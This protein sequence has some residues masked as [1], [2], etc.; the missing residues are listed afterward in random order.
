MGSAGLA[1]AIGS[2]AQ[3]AAGKSFTGY[4]DSLGV[5][6]DTVLCVGCRSCEAACNKVND[7]PPP[8]SPFNDLTLLD[9]KRRTTATSYT[10]VNRYMAEGD[11]QRPMFRKNQCNHCLEP[12]CAS[13]CFVKAFSKT[14]SGAVTYDPSVCVGCRYC[15]IACPFEIPS[16]EYDSALSPRVTKCTLC[17]PRIVK[18]QLPGCVESCP[19]EA[20]V[21][22]KR[23]DLIRIARQRIQK[24]PDRY[25]D[26][27]YGEY[28]M[29]GT[30]WL[31]LSGVPFSRLGLREDLGTL[32]AAEYTAG[33]LGAVPMVVGLWPVLLTGVYAIAKRRDKIA[34]EE[35]AQA[36]TQALTQ[37][38]HQAQS[39][40]KAALDKAAKEKEAAVAKAVKEALDAAAKERAQKE[41]AKAA[42]VADQSPASPASTKEDA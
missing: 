31:Y 6:H 28:E 22:G 9:Q 15:M 35:T 37:A 20:L 32:P 38:D 19:T 21:F 13:A 26:H 36:V 14:P 12:A 8:A 1:N 40:L 24:F 16:Y 27:I 10:V 3:A 18:G 5:L 11:M 39:K 29:G 30:S 4:P 2:R 7:L 42:A 25:V 23:A 41:A 33:A 34:A 17:H